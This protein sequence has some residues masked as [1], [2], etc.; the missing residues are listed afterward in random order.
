MPN[1]LTGDFDVVA[2]FS[3][4]AVN[5]VLAAMHC[6]ERFPH[7]MTLRVD[8]DLPAGAGIVR[9]SAVASVDAFGEPTVNQ[10]QIRGPALVSG[11]LY[12]TS[13]LRVLLDPVVNPGGLIVGPVVPSR[14]KGRAQLQF[15][16]PSLDAF[17]SSG[18]NVT[19]RVV[20]RSRYFPDP[21]TP[22]VAEFLRGELQITVRVNQVVSQAANVID[23]DIKA[24]T[25]A[26]N[27]IP[28]NQALSDADLA[29]IIQLVRNILKTSFLPSNTPLPSNIRY[30]QF[31]TL[32]GAQ[33]ALAVLLNTQ[34]AR[35][36]PGG[37]SNAFLGGGDDFGLAVGRDFIV[38]AFQPV[39]D[40]IL[41]QPIPPVTFNVPLLVTTLHVTYTF[42]LN[43]V[44]IDL[45]PGKIVLTIQ[46]HAHTGKRYAPDFDFT[47][48]QDFTLSVDGAT[49]DLV[50]GDI[51]LDTSSWVANQFKNNALP[52]IERAR[53]QALRDSDA[54]GAVRNLLSADATLGGFLK[55]LLSADNQKTAAQPV[56]LQLAY[57][58]ID[59]QPSGIV[60]HGRLSAD[61]PPAHA[62]F[63][64][65]PAIPRGPGPGGIVARGPDYSALKSW[66]PGGVIEEYEWSYLQG[67]GAPVVVD[68]DRFVYLDAHL[69]AGYGPLCLTVRGSQLPPSGPGAS[70]PVS[71]FTCGYLV[72]PIINGVKVGVDGSL[73]M[74]ALAQPDPRGLLHVAGHTPA[75]VDKTGINTPNLIVHFADDK[76][77]GGLKLL[78]EALQDSRRDDAPAAI[79][80]VLTPD[81]LARAPYQAGIIYTEDQG[82]SWQRV[83]GVKDARRPLTL[84]VN[85]KGDV[86]WQQEGALDRKTLSAALIKVLVPGGPLKLDVPQVSLRLGQPAPNLLFEFAPGRQLT[87]RKLAG[88]AAVLVF[89]KS[90]VR[91]SIEAVRDLQKSA[92]PEG[93]RNPVLLAINDGDLG[94]VAKRVAAESGLSAIQV[95]DP[96]REI[97]AAY[98][99]TLWPTIVSIDKF[100]LVQG[101]RYGR[102]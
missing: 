93:G 98:G 95:I 55:S 25:I 5:R 56:G 43:N 68:R 28:Q 73:P 37:F 61:W 66:I 2:E 65:I 4:P 42:S 6:N 36:D 9:P 26:I 87:L 64:Q 32:P 29:G 84:V 83:F 57:T 24:D 17:D 63:E 23:I 3:T 86:V 62:A 38:A 50:V 33:S 88:R 74:V 101:V 16:P 47:V 82:G 91:P 72:N 92:N 58:S 79:L 45:R 67:Q 1:D 99:V 22:P 11:Q 59:I 75:Q 70:Q 13:P 21:H 71:A 31:K 19:G 97:A 34:S 30:L 10:N 89:W 41:S 69:L 14:L 44:T 40:G 76:S 46:G 94:D 12:I 53:D 77:A 54:P 27:F 35:G 8:D 39:I 81:Q 18:T 100:G 48:T 78:T 51:S 96:K 49:A 52:S 7:S 102:S 80:T 20:V 85:P 60:L 90:A 15:S